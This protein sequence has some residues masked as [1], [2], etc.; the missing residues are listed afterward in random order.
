MA[1]GTGIQSQVR[2]KF[3]NTV[4]Y[5]QTNNKGTKEQ[6]SRMYQ[7]AVKN[8]K[9]YSQAVQR[10]RL[11]PIQALYS[12]LKHIITRSFEG[13]RYG[14]PS[15][16]KFL[17]L[18]MSRYGGPYVPKGTLGSVPGPLV[19]SAGSL[20]SIGTNFDFQYA[21]SLRCN[22]NI[23]FKAEPTTY[24]W[25]EISYFLINKTKFIHD[26]D[27]LTFLICG[28][29][30]ANI[31]TGTDFQWFD[32]SIIVDT[33]SK[34][35][36]PYVLLL[37]DENYKELCYMLDSPGSQWATVASACILSRKSNTG[38]HL[39]S[40]SVI[41]CS[42]FLDRFITESAFYEAIMTYMTEQSINQTW[43][44]D[45]DIPNNYVRTAFMLTAQKYWFSNPWSGTTTPPQ[46]F[47]YI[48]PTGE[49]GIFT[50][51]LTVQGQGT[52]TVPVNSGGLEVTLDNAGE[53]YHLKV[54]TEHVLTKDYDDWRHNR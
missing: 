28:I 31:W 51:T 26:G 49:L 16:Q 13:V 41:D 29:P 27:Q 7:P 50:D 9:S 23:R 36:N 18:N 34:E 40:T 44:T 11:Q 5:L 33:K 32:Y 1:I 53:V 12:S 20:T 22:T 30:S 2:G 52:I 15:H 25:G 46:I 54:N 6:V 42:P 17:S 21:S 3:A 37:G 10:M 48:T 8:P 24:D 4:Y 47:G 43:P 45:P 14:E 39:R 38:T 35:L 19:I